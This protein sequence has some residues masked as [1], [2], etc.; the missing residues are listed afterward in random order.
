[1]KNLILSLISVTALTALIGCGEKDTT[2]TADA[3]KSV[4]EKADEAASR[5][6][7]DDAKKSAAAAE[8]KAQAA[9]DAAEKKAKEAAKAAE[10]AAKETKEGASKLLNSFKN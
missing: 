7:A 9:A 6:T 10:K 4:A 2:N 1:M 3:T 5:I 8:A